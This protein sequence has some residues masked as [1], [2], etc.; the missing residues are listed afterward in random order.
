MEICIVQIGNIERK[1]LGH[2]LKG[3]EEAFPA[4]TCRIL[5]NILQ[6]PEKAYNPIRGQ[7][8]SE[9]ILKE[10]LNYKLKIESETGSPCILLGIVDVDIYAQG[11]NFIFGEA[12]CP[13]RAAII[14]L[15]RLRPE[16]YGEPPKEQLFIE[17]SIKE[18]VHEIGHTCGLIHC[19]NP[20]CVMHFSLHIG[21]TDRKKFELCER[22]LERL[23]W[24]MEKISM[25]LKRCAILRFG[26]NMLYHTRPRKI[27]AL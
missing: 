9:P 4:C 21:M 12:Q 11:M 1:I 6:L 7:Y 13:G 14:S 22:C 10:T 19:S 26:I 18:A 8:R 27:F 2:I 16:F 25:R 23:K 24:N 15:Y 17:R 3:I 5:E 20:L